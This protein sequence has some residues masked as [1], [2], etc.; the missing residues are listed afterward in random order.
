MIRI[1]KPG[2][3]IQYEFICTECGCEYI[4]D[5]ADVNKFYKENT[6]NCPNCGKMNFGTEIKYKEELEK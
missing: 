2:K 5:L 3:T 1:T 6:C 4:A